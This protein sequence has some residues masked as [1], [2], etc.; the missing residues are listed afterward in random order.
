MTGETWLK[1]LAE[2]NDLTSNLVHLTKPSGKKS[3]L[4]VL[5]KIL[6]EQRLKGS[7][8][9]SGFIVGKTPAVCFQD[10][11]LYSLSQNIYYEQKLRAANENEK[12]RYT[13]N[14][15]LFS[16]NRVFK[17]GGRPVI[18]DETS[19]AK[20]YLPT[21]EYW[22]IVN[23]NLKNENAIIDWTHEREWRVPNELAFDLNEVT[24]LV[25]NLNAQK[26]FVEKFEEK[27]KE[28]PLKL[29]KGV[30]NLSQIFY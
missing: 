27:F 7:T 13:G 14:G 25:A 30:I 19:K 17:K 29:L 28:N 22:R 15:L 11:P 21:S 3:V 26:K 24:V 20:K 5:L 16:K 9:S 10:T 18:Y 4:D 12:M 1:R 23:F 8:T 2:R 6:D